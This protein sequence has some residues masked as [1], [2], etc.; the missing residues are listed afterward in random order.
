M[1]YI[2]SIRGFGTDIREFYIYT[3]LGGLEPIS[4]SAIY[5]IRGFGADIRE[6]YIY[7]YIYIYS[8]RE[9]GTDIREYYIYIYIYI[10]IYYLVSI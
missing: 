6:C 3:V 2:Y 10:Y 4:G 1:L 5:S 9:F 8:I 7:I